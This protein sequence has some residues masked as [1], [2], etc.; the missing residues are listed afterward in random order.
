MTARNGPR[1]PFFR[2]VSP[3]VGELVVRPAG[4]THHG[5]HLQ[6]RRSRL[7]FV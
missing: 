7:V 5:Y 6:P 1:V 3:T 2:P 4:F